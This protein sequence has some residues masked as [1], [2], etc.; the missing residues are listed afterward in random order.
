MWLKVFCD[1]QVHRSR[2]RC[3]C[4]RHEVIRL[5][6]IQLH[7]FLTSTISGGEWSASRPGKLLLGERT[8]VPIRQKG[9]GGVATE[10]VQRFRRRETPLSP[11]SIRTTNRPAPKLVSV[12]TFL[13]LFQKR[14][15]TNAIFKSNI[16]VQSY[17]LCLFIVRCYTWSHTHGH[18][19]HSVGLPWTRDRSCRTDLCLTTHDNDQRQISIRW[20]LP[21][22][23]LY[24][25][26]HCSIGIISG[27]HHEVDGNCTLLGCYAA[28]SGN[29]LT[30]FR[31]SWTLKMW[32]I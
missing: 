15:F 11:I 14:S 13:I 2:Y 4:E 17:P 30:I 25:T 19:P 7:S 3:P 23:H 28:C 22:R 26:R 12:P 29:F 9:E 31:G 6:E 20:A 10:Q 8:P 27:F 32:S 16:I 21:W 1:R 5:V 18:T 24:G